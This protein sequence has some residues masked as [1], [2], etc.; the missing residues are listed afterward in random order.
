MSMAAAEAAAV[1][2]VVFFDGAQSINLGTVAVHPALGFKRFQA[3]IA[4]LIGVAPHQISASLVRPRRARAAAAE[5]SGRRVPIDESSD[6]A[7]IARD[8]GSPTSSPRSEG[9]GARGGPIAPRRRGRRRCRRGR[10]R[11]SE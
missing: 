11:R 7:A 4:Q 10:E 3:A 8:A 5:L 2:P 1:I 9:P 6:L